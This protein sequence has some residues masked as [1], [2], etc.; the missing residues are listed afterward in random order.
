[1]SDG[2]ADV[3]TLPSGSATSD[4]AIGQDL[5]AIDTQIDAAGKDTASAGASVDAAQ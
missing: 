2:S 1:M 4:Q 5:S 3:Q